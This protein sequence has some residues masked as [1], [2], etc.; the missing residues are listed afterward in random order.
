MPSRPPKTVVADLVGQPL[1]GLQL[2][3]A[4]Q[5][6]TQGSTSDSDPGPAMGQLPGHCL[7]QAEVLIDVLPYSLIDNVVNHA[8]WAWSEFNGF[9]G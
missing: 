7:R 8:L 3:P 1:Q 6:R 4:Q 5:D 9:A 2:L